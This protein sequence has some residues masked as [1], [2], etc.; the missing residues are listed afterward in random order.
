MENKL[1]CIIIKDLLPIY[2]DEIA[3]KET[4]ACV[5]QHLNECDTCK[6]EYYKMLDVNN[7]NEKNSEIDTFRKFKLKIILMFVSLIMISV[8]CIS[9]AMMC[10][11]I[12]LGLHRIST[13]EIILMVIFNIGI[14]FIPM[15]ALLFCWIWKKAS[16]GSSSYNISNSFFISLLIIVIYLITEL[17]Y[18][19]ID[20]LNFL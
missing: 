15:M 5:E 11:N 7:S 18:K 16:Y 17:L 8:A 20:L 3:S 10:E 6:K 4:N 19:Y 14:Y 1:S 12:R 13:K 9:V 2:I